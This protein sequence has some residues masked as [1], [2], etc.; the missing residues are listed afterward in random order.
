M[1]QMRV[2]GERKESMKISV[3]TV[4]YNSE[5]TIERTIRSVIAQDYHDLEYIII[6]GASTDKTLDIIGKY[7]NEISICVSEPDNGLYDAMNKG[8]EKCSGDV[9]A[10]LNSDDWYA[11]NVLKKV[12]EYFESSNA[13]I[14]SGNL[15]LFHDGVSEKLNFDRSNREKML[16]EVIY[17]HPA[18]F[19]KR[20]LY[21]KHGG[22]DTSYKLAADTD[23]VMK[24]C[25]NGA[26]V[27]CADDCFT[28]FSDGG[29]SFRK[30]YAG[31]KEQYQIACKY[32]QRDAFIHLENDLNEYYAKKLDETRKW[33]CLRNAFETRTEEIKKLFDYENTYY[34]WGAGARG[35]ECLRT[36]E[37][38]GLSVAGFID[39]EKKKVKLNGYRVISPDDADIKTGKN[40]CITPKGYEEGII[41]RLK[42][43]GIGE[44]HYFLYTDMLDQIASLG[45]LEE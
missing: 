4:C 33:E 35:M 41:L 36:F 44:N 20:E 42:D 26:D 22:F 40:I 13:D 18:L 45:S 14:V 39:S 8:L 31:L 19:A 3:I 16:F 29:L 1:Q 12:N 5:A 23:W 24:V 6:D 21:V 37:R 32:V 2:T 15:Y 10:F 17:P 9:F 38:L 11:D 25:V 27:F 30:R 34:I 43:M 28:H 7:Q